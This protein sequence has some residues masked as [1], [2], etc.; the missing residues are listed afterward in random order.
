MTE[1]S[2]VKQ[3]EFD[4]MTGRHAQAARQL[5][6]LARR[7]HGELQGAGLD[8]SPATRL[9]E[10]AGRV[11]TQAEDL[12][13]R[14]KLVRELQ[15]QKVSF[16]T[17][18]PAG[19]FLE[20][21]D[22]LDAAKSLLDGT[23]AGRAALNASR[24]DAKALAELEKYA[25]RA[26]DAEFVKVFL[27]VLGAG[28]AT[29]LPGAIATQLRA[30]SKH[31][32]LA[33]VASL[34]AQG[35]RALGMLS[36]TLA[37]ATDP[38]NPAY[39]GADF[40]RD[41][42][43][44]GRTEHKSGDMKY[45]GYQ[46]QAL[47]WR[48]HEGKP[49]YSKEFMEI[50]GRDVI[51][52]EREQRESAWKASEDYSWVQRPILDLA[53]V[54]GLGTLLRPGTQAGPP[55]AKSSS[56]VVDDLF[57]AAKS[58]REASHALLAHTP[59]GWK[60]SMLD[61]LLTTRWGVSRYLGNYAPL[62]DML[63]TATT[64]QDATSQALAA[65]M[66]KIVADEVRSAFEQG[67]DGNLTIRN[68]ETFDRLAPLSYP[69]A[70]AI[71]ANIDQLSELLLNKGSFGEV[72][73]GDMS[74]ALVL[75]T[76]DNAGFE[77]LVR[78]QTEHMRAALETVPPVGLTASNAE[79]F[80][81]TKSDIKQF[82][83]D[84]DGRVTKDDILHSLEDRTKEEASPFGHIVEIR[85][86]TLIAQGLDD[87]KVDESLKTMVRNAIG[88]LPVPGTRQV[89]ELAVGAFGELISKQ[90][91]KLAGAT[92]DEIAKHVAQQMSAHRGGLDEANQ[93]I[94]N[95]RLA[96]E[97]LT[98]QMLAT[99]ILNKGLLDG[100][101]LKNQPFAADT[102]PKLKPF[103][104][105]S[106]QEY[107]QFLA[108]ARKSGGISSVLTDFE[109]TFRTTSAVNDYLGLKIPSSVGGK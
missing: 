42:V 60:E 7:L 103:I 49:P 36:R 98:E 23:L 76:S 100:R 75:A 9:R 99:T 101:E 2:G 83:L 74:Y 13:R 29:R 51:V 93:T 71:S 68:R 46:A 31:G 106:S 61:Y 108:W 58:S 6:E 54:L 78:A 59:A 85:R 47:I 77:A 1:F 105:M 40:T 52:Y 15:R 70:R 104:E 19:S 34:S 72:K 73:A 84:E 27:S 20:M 95:N 86:Q 18:T 16:G 25:S 22:G 97:R 17:S 39:M 94:A 92:Y 57:H 48:A 81:F 24:G 87:K 32:D 45:S 26:G 62:N 80:G 50:V 89:S 79:Q 44:Q 37:K 56:S 28:G 43:K 38:K 102:P 96:V 53:S 4:T 14:Q 30:A 82:D 21:P 109:T 11:T 88:L 90:Y 55:G 69:L 107:S 8:T 91:D 67:A 63:V 66:T 5:E 64:G 33:R 65:K 41:L 35:Q 3:P 10:L 12:R